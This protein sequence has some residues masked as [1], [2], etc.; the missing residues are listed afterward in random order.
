MMSGRQIRKKC[1]DWSVG[2]LHDLWEW[3]LH[4]GY[5]WVRPAHERRVF[6]IGRG[7]TGT[8]TV[9]QCLSILG[10]RSFHWIRHGAEP[11][12]GWI[13]YIRRRNFDALADDP[14]CRDQFYR[15]LDEAFPES[16]FILTVRDEESWV[17][18]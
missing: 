10:Y 7:K 9:S 15:Q 11:R 5:P 3:S 2:V 4:A 18:S 6:C 14:L 8:T 17:K 12:E 16:R 13:A 1:V